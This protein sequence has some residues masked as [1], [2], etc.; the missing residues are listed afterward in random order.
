MWPSR[1]KA[2]AL[3]RC[4]LMWTTRAV[5]FHRRGMYV[6]IAGPV[7]FDLLLCTHLAA[8]LPY[9][10]IR[11]YWWRRCRFLW[12]L[13]IQHPYSPSFPNRC[14]SA[15]SASCIPTA[16]TTTAAP[17]TT[18]TKATTTGTAEEETKTNT[19]VEE[20]PRC[21]TGACFFLLLLLVC[22]RRA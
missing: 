22:L 9:D 2:I 21:D 8:I 6:G 19:L 14:Y 3:T 12:T 16:D 18:T 17:T 7:C 20:F 1:P 4:C 13:M 15:G 10:P 5:A 11:G